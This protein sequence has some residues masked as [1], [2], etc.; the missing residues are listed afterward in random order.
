[1]TASD[2]AKYYQSKEAM[3][4]Y[5][6]AEQMA[7]FKIELSKIVSEILPLNLINVPKGTDYTALVPPTLAKVVYG[8]GT[9]ENRNIVWNYSTY[10][11]DVTGLQ[12]IEG[13]VLLPDFIDTVENRN[14]DKIRQFIRVVDT[15]ESDII[16]VIHLSDVADYE[17]LEPVVASYGAE[18]RAIDLPTEVKVT[19]VDEEGELSERMMMVNWDYSAFTELTITS[20]VELKGD[21]VIGADENITNILNIRPKVSIIIPYTGT[22]T[23]TY[24][25]KR[26]CVLNAGTSFM[27]SDLVN[28]LDYVS[29]AMFY[30]VANDPS[31]RLV[32]IR[33]TGLFDDN[34]VNLTPEITERYPEGIRMPVATSTDDDVAAYLAALREFDDVLGYPLEYE[35]PGGPTCPRVLID[36]ETHRLNFGSI[37]PHNCGFL[38][39]RS[40]NVNLPY[41]DIC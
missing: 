29:T 11:P 12:I 28:R 17:D 20:G 22:V 23:P 14:I 16:E 3:K 30:G 36:D 26:G 21:I 6:S 41:P 13:T 1:M 19:L 10:D 24:Q 15:S 8:D 39:R 27:E 31:Q 40:A 7:N 2:V 4:F 38:I 18:L 9:V 35:V 34:G 25:Y 32:D 5:V 33:F 37:A